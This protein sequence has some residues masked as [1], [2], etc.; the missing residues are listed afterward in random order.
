V[1]AERRLLTDARRAEL[2]AYSP[3]SAAR[4][5]VEV[6]KLLDFLREDGAGDNLFAATPEDIVNFLIMKDRTGCTRVHNQACP[7]WGKKGTST[8][9]CPKRQKYS[10]MRTTRYILQGAFRDRGATAPWSPRD[11]TGNPCKSAWVDKH[12]AKVELE[13]SCAGVG[14]IQ[15]TLVDVSVYDR[16][17]THTLGEWAVHRTTDPLTAALAARD[18]LFYATLWETGF[19]AADALHLSHQAVFPVSSPDG[20]CRGISLKVTQAKQISKPEES[21]NIVVWDTGSQYSLPVAYRVYQNALDELAVTLAERNGP[22]FRG[23]PPDEDG[24]VHLQA[25]CPWAILDKRYAERLISLRFSVEA[26]AHMTLHSFHGSRAAREKLAGVPCSTTCTSMR[27]S[28]K[29]YNYYTEGRVAMSV[30]NITVM[31]DA[32]QILNCV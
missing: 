31:W 29:S 2:V 1:G 30:N 25:G 19:R 14:T 21:F 3:P 7:Q 23:I 12:M 32:D 6:R 8:C 13:Q 10:S 27:W 22:L 24:T 28:E 5:D 4:A 15:S 11:F 17:V 26:G 20:R 16:V 18:A 9:D